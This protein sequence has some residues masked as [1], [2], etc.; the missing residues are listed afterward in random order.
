MFIQPLGSPEH[1]EDCHNLIGRTGVSLGGSLRSAGDNRA[2]YGVDSVEHSKVLGVGENATKQGLCMLERMPA[3]TFR[4][5][6]RK[7]VGCVNGFEVPQP[8]LAHSRTQG[9]LPELC[10]TMSG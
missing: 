9:I 2:L 3:P 10:V 4:G 5:V 7:C 6:I 1:I 8:N